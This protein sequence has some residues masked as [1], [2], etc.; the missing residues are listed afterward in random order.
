MKPAA[1]YIYMPRPVRAI[2]IPPF[3]E[4]P[5][6]EWITSLHEMLAG[7]EWDSGRDGTIDLLIEVNG[8]P[9]FTANPGDWIVVEHCVDCEPVGVM[10]DAQF[11][12]RFA[13]VQENL[14][15]TTP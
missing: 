3:G 10:T 6:S 14:H 9:A 8:Q 5:S 4:D 13:P 7:I 2:Q 1:T 11:R 12:L 15:A